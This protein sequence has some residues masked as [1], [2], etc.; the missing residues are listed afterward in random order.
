MRSIEPLSAASR[1]M[2]GMLWR[3]WYGGERK[4][5][6]Q[7]MELNPASRAKRVNST[8]SRNRLMGVSVLGCCGM[9]MMP[10]LITVCYLSSYY[11][12][13]S[14]QVPSPLVGEGQGEEV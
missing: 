13:T 2:S 8:V 9:V 7:A 10:N 1:A 6:P 5:C 14:V 11:H 4:C 12:Y 3:F